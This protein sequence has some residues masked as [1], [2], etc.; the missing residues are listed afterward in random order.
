MKSKFD[1][2]LSPLSKVDAYESFKR[3]SMYVKLCAWNEGE[4]RFLMAEY[5]MKTSSNS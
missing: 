4:K 1:L 2:Y 3:T 5:H